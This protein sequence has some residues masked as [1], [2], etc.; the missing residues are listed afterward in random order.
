MST[1]V[2]FSDCR[3]VIFDFSG[4][5]CSDLYFR[6][7]PTNCPRWS[8][9][10][11]REIFGN[12]ATIDRWTRG[13]LTLHDMAKHLSTILSRDAES[14][15]DVM[16]E[17]CRNLKLDEAVLQFAREQ[18]SNGIPTALVTGNLDLFTDV[19]VPSHH[20]DRKFDVIVNSFD[21]GVN[22]RETLWNIAFGE[23]GPKISF[24]GSLLIDDR[25]DNIELFSKLGGRTYHYRGNSSFL[26]DMHRALT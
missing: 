12:H 7:P 19:V 17:G 9:T 1:E 5:V 4:T 20:L 14:I 21:Y 22:D 3:S 23:I 2:D 18:R 6:M 26:D 8:E 11:Q 24:S 16:K 25:Q 10:I 13:E 15:V